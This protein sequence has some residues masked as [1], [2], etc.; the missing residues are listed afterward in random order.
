MT[1]RRL[2][3]FIL[4]YA[5]TFFALDRI[6]GTAFD[7]LGLLLQAVIIGAFAFAAFRVKNTPSKQGYI[8]EDGVYREREVGG[9]G[10]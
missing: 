9:N 1:A 3:V 6:N 7:L 8:D 10:S 2:I 5:V 4:V